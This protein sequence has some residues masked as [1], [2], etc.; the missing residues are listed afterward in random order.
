MQAFKNV[1]LLIGLLVIFCFS[2]LQVKNN[3]LH[4][5]LVSTSSLTSKTLPFQYIPNILY[6]KDD[7]KPEVLIL[8]SS[9]M[10]ELFFHNK[11]LHE[12]F[13]SACSRE[14]S[15]FNAASSEQNLSDS[16]SVIEFMDK[17]KSLPKKIF[18]EISEGRLSA[19]SSFQSIANNHSF[20]LPISENLLSN[21]NLNQRIFL[22]INHFLHMMRWWGYENLVSK[23]DTSYYLVEDRNMYKDETLEEDSLKALI[24]ARYYL[25][26]D[27]Y[28]KNSENLIKNYLKLLSRYKERTDIYFIYLP[29][30]KFSWE[31]SK[32]KKEYKEKVLAHIKK[33]NF[34]VIDI[35]FMEELAVEDYYDSQHLVS[36]G[37][38]KFWETDNGK[39][40]TSL[41]CS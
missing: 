35:E 6:S 25:Q 9:G 16:L 24:Q 28:K 34:E 21:L 13:S 18:I 37:R 7:L 8:G 32:E 19:D 22:K 14:V 12:L 17:N 31:Y 26:E 40:I 1:T 33:V 15:A 3:N 39:K 10:R 36:K 27:K 29:R 11:K 2:Y 23:L 4:K 38:D 20:Y 41:A 30:S 5:L